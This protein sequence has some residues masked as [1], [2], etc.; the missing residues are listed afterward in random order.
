MTPIE[1]ARLW[2]NE[3]GQLLANFLNTGSGSAVAARID[4]LGLSPAQASGLRR[5]LD[6]ALTDTM[7]TLLLGLDGGA[8]IGGRQETYSLYA[9]S[10]E[11][12][13]SGA[14][15]A[16]MLQ[17]FDRVELGQEEPRTIS[18]EDSVQILQ[19]KLDNY[20]Q[21]PEHRVRVFNPAAVLKSVRDICRL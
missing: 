8:S 10:G 6:L 15:M 4:A 14:M 12:L 1:F 19:A 9:E 3:K 7:Y 5:A 2:H 18:C 16:E 20:F 21:N 13:L 11:R 17:G